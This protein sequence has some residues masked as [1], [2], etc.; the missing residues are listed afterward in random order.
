MRTSWRTVW[1]GLEGLETRECIEQ[2]RVVV[3]H[4]EHRIPGATVLFIVASACG[5]HVRCERSV[6]SRSYPLPVFRACATDA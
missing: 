2:G 5:V 1:I 6:V 4:S 3:L